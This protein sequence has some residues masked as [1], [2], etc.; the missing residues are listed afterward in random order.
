LQVP[1]HEDQRLAEELGVGGL[2]ISDELLMQL[3]QNLPDTKMDYKT[4]YGFFD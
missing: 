1:N 3:K 2:P 4:I